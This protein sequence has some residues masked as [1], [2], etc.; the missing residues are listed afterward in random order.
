MEERRRLKRKYLAFFTRV[1]DCETGQLVGNLDNVSPEGAMLIGKHPIQ[2]DKDFQLRMDVSE[3]FFGK[4]HLRFRARSVWC[5]PDL[6]P[7]FY[8]IGFQ[9]LEI[10]SE[11]IKIIEQIMAEYG[12]HD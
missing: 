11:D 10:A 2:Q 4:E 3:H 8:N 12:I 7:S 9:F 6:D 1:I 5:Q